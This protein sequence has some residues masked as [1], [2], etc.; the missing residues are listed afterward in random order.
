MIFVYNLLW[1]ELSECV[2]GAA[3][4][5]GMAKLATFNFLYE[6][7]GILL[8]ENRGSHKRDVDVK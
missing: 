8:K 7:I 4:G 3:S 5:P 1:N 2:L 6:C